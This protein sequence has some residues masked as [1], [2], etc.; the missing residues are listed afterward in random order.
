MP[1]SVALAD[2]NLDGALD[3][4][5]GTSLTEG[6][7]LLLGDG[8]GGFTRRTFLDARARSTDALLGDLDDDGSTDVVVINTDVDDQTAGTRYASTFRSRERSQGR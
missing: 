2:L 8:D 5:I 6:A 3:V 7:A 1:E 4:V